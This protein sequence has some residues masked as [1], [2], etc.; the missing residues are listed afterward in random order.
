MMKPKVYSLKG[1]SRPSLD[2]ERRTK[3]KGLPTHKKVQRDN[4][5]Y[6]T[7]CSIFFCSSGTELFPLTQVLTPNLGRTKLESKSHKTKIKTRIKMLFKFMISPFT[8]FQVNEETQK[9]W[10]GILPRHSKGRG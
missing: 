5:F 3:R 7:W 1:K 10:R 2:T 4:F 8:N 9:L 6:L